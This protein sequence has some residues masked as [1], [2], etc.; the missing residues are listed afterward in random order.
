MIVPIDYVPIM[1]ISRDLQ[2]SRWKDDNVR[3][4]GDEP[5]QSTLELG[6]VARHHKGC[7]GRHPLK[8]PPSSKAS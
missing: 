8:L 5:L 6:V 2:P 7:V 4:A 1:G 3:Q